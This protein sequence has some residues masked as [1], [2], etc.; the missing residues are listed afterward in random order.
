MFP[1][2]YEQL[3]DAFRL[4]AALVPYLYTLAHEAGSTGLAPARPMYYSWP[5]ADGAYA[6]THQHMLG[7]SVLA[8]A[9]S[10]ISWAGNGGAADNTTSRAVWLPPGAWA[11]WDGAQL[12]GGA[13]GALVTARAAFN[14]T[15][16]FV[17]AGTLLPLAAP[18]GASATSPDLVWVYFAA[19]AGAGGAPARA[20]VWEDGG[21]DEGDAGAVTAAEVR[22]TGA[23]MTLALAPAAR[24]APGAYPALPAA[25][26]VEMQLRGQPRG[27]PASVTVDG[28]P[29]GPL[30][31]G[32]PVG[33]VGW[34]VVALAEH[35]LTA[36]V[37]ALR[38]CAGRLSTGEMH[39]VVVAY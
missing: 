23:T 36:P 5:A 8:A 1:S 28:A 26:G 7:D 32:A 22:V 25:R 27:A 12:D 4:R 34:R 14:A 10:V 17:P 38:V 20:R 15:P 11:A 35:S 39:E 24:A 18:G 29:L 30:P 3:A 19:G 31:A 37:G 9:L 13:R 6:A 2:I 21:A 33:A 16:L